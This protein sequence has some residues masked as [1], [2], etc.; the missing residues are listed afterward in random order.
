MT[1]VPP[2]ATRRYQE[3][4]LMELTQLRHFLAA[5]K[6][7]NLV[8]AAEEENITQSGMSRSIINL[9]RKLDMPLLERNARGIFPTPFGLSLIPQ[10]ELILNQAARATRE[11]QSIKNLHIGSVNMGV[12]L[13][14]SH[15]FIPSVL[16]KIYGEFPSIQIEIESGS[17]SEL[18]EGV[19][20]SKLDFF[21]GLIKLDEQLTGLSVEELFSTRSLI[22]CNRKH[23]LLRKR[24]VSLEDLSA[25]Q[26]AMLSSASFQAAFTSYFYS[27]RV[28][29]PHQVLKTNSISILRHAVRTNDFLTILPRE[30]VADDL[31]SGAFA[32]IAAEVPADSTPAALVYKPEAIFTPAINFVMEQIRTFARTSHEK[33]N[34]CEA[35]RLMRVNAGA[36]A[37]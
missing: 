8:K 1:Q 22:V 29:S 17:F 11:L 28:A 7:G 24:K 36:K 33:D 3:A 19:R 10:A 13:N 31:D 32:V 30:L 23:P 25:A 21:F 4:S 12:T 37:P 2:K 35:R 20:Q 5:V 18:V 15:Y 16:N 26:W 14:Y 34:E 27:K 6:H 9:E